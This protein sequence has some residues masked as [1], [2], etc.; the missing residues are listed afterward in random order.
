MLPRQ[1]DASLKLDIFGDDGLLKSFS[2]GNYLLE[3]G[4]DWTAKDLR[5]AT[6]LVDF[7][8]T[9]IR[10]EVGGWDHSYDFDIVF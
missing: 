3:S 7:A 6:V 4:Y 10:I 9:Q 2:L 1:R 8:G 5:D